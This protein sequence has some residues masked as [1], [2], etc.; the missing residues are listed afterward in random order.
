MLA[1]HLCSVHG[2]RRFAVMLGPE[3]HDHSVS[4]LKSLK[5]ALSKRNIEISG[6]DIYYGD[7]WYNKGEETAEKILSKR[8][9]PD[10]V[11]CI[12]D[13]MA[14]SLVRAFEKRGAV[15]TG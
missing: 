15:S 4:R 5:K 7:F 8:S 3:G 11:M 9:L 2:C 1:E 13:I 10:A 6:E 12:S 14:I